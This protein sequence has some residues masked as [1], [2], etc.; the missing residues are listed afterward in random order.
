MASIEKLI[1]LLVAVVEL[2]WFVNVFI[3][4][5]VSRQNEVGFEGVLY[6]LL[7]IVHLQQYSFQLVLLL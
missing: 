3:V 2:Y 6:L 4:L 7:A 5:L 1:V